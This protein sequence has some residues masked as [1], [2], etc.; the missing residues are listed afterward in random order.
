MI[1]IIVYT[2]LLYFLFYLIW[3]LPE[4]DVIVLLYCIITPA[5]QCPVLGPYSHGRKWVN[6]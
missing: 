4:I 1:L 6:G 3:A 2:F 5:G